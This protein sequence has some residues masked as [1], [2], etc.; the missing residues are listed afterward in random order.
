MP[1][2]RR[3]GR[4]DDEDNTV[5]LRQSVDGPQRALVIVSIVA[6]LY[7]Q[8]ELVDADVLLSPIVIRAVPLLEVAYQPV[9]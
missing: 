8:Q 1:H 2:S 9:V 6:V 3:L 5:H 4:V 7:V